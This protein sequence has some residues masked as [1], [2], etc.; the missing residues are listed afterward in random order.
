MYNDLAVG[1]CRLRV[2]HRLSQLYPSPRDAG[3]HYHVVQRTLPVQTPNPNTCSQGIQTELSEDVAEMCKFF[4]EMMKCMPPSART[5]LI[6][7]VTEW[8]FKMPLP[9]DFI[10]LSV[11]AIEHRRCGRSNVLYGL[12]KAVGHMRSDG[13]DSRLP[14]K[15]MPMGD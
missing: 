5:E 8:H 3:Q 1:G 15:R 2:S 4:V 14:A 9:Q 6:Q 12:A 10:P 11:M 7:R 13:S